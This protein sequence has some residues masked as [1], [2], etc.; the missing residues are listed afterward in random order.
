MH[1]RAHDQWRGD[2]AKPLFMCGDPRLD[3]LHDVSARCRQIRASNRARV[4]W[5]RCSAGQGTWAARDTVKAG[6]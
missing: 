4:L 3:S 5:K 6:Q 1:I 2:D